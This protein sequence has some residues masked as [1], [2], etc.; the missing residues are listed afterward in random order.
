[1]ALRMLERL[2][3]L[4]LSDDQRR[5][6]AQQDLLLISVR[7]HLTRLLNTRAGSVLVDPDFGVPD[8][9]S[10]PGN[11]VM[12]NAD[13]MAQAMLAVVHRYEP[14]L[15]QQSLRIVLSNDDNVSIRLSLD[16]FLLDNGKQRPVSLKGV[17]SSDG[18]IEFDPVA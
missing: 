3:T 12:V 16:G 14:R 7:H 11:S 9:S 4:D 10:G 6:M 13:M 1:M 17:V 15:H 8:M 2:A 5:V 18:T